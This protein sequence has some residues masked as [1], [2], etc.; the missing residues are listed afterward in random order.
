MEEKKGNEERKGKGNKEW[1][2]DWKKGERY[3]RG[4]EGNEKGGA[5]GRDAP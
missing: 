4:K 1:N 2:V 3:R 5:R